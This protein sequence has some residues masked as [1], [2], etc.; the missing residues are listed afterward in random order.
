MLPP[1]GRLIDVGTHRL[2]VRCE[3]QGAPAVVFD[4][5][6]GASSLSW[7]LVQPAVA[8][9][10]QACTYDRAGFAWS[11]AGPLPRT[12]G[13]I[14]DEL[15]EVLRRAPVPPPYVLVGHSFGGLVMRLLTS[16]QPELVAALVLIEPAVAEEWA[17]PGPEQR[18]LVARGTRLCA[19][20]A[21]AARIGVA[22]TVAML[23]RVGALAVARSIVRVVSRGGLRREDEGV[24]AP[25][26]KLPREVRRVLADMWT[27]PKFFQ[28][29]GSQIE[30]ICVSA[31]EALREA[32]RSYGDLPLVVITAA[33]A[34]EQRVHA[35]AA[36]ASLSTRGRHIFAPHSGHWI[37]LDAPQ[38]VID[39]IIEVVQ[40]VRV[41]G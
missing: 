13:R 20:G 25:I 37:P 5:A 40:A 33:G 7:S 9:V 8:Q 32:P 23:A 3:G 18:A 29:L 1:P 12:A 34:S 17:E 26:W 22:R 27:Q 19:Y 36:L 16:R 24:L 15:H 35:D 14:A 30:N 6:L 4:A 41:K 2:H 11:D 21:T 28:A 39:T 10:T 38:V 31:A